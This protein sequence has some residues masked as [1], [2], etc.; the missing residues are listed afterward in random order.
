[1]PSKFAQKILDLPPIA[2][3]TRIAKR[4]VLPG[5]EGIALYEVLVFFLRGVSK[6]AVNMRASSV[7]FSFFLAIFPSIIFLFTLI[8]YI[9][10]DNFQNELFDVI[11]SVMPKA[12]F[13]A[14]ESTLEDII[15]RQNSG[16]LSFGFITALYFATN[17]F[18]AVINA[19]NQTYHSVE[20]RK[21]FMTRLVS[22]ALV[23][24]QTTLLI[25]AIAII[26]F[27]EILLNKISLLSNFES[28]L[29]LIGRAITVFALFFCTLSFIYYLAPSSKA[30]WRFIS[31]GSTFA[32][33]LTVITCWGFAFYINNF[34]QYNK[35]YGS[36]G[37]LIVILL[38]I[39]FNSYI[40]LLGFELNASIDMAKKKGEKA[41]I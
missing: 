23:L 34:G 33:I 14:T 2:K 8:P 3:L 13:E 21:P 7:A 4:I 41:I 17:G 39:Y 29:I 5:F 20:T 30:R 10:I 36:I 11:K 32:A 18:V 15:K 26:I 40:L 6:G 12:A 25:T 16:L 22:I 19:F 27:S 37:T 35:L 24:I 28:Y 38:W 31:A 9:P 1:M